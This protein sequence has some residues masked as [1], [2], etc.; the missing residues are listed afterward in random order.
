MNL[1]IFNNK[2]AKLITAAL[3]LIAG[4][5]AI[6]GCGGG[7]SSSSTA[8]PRLYKIGDID[9]ATIA[10]LNKAKIEVV[11]FDPSMTNSVPAGSS[12]VFDH[13]SIEL[14]EKQDAVAAKILQCFEAG[15]EV[16]LLSSDKSEREYLFKNI[17]DGYSA[18]TTDEGTI[19]VFGVTREKNGSAR[20]FLALGASQTSG[21][22]IS[23]DAPGLYAAESGDKVVVISGDE[24]LGTESVLDNNFQLIIT[25][26]AIVASG[27]SMIFNCDGA[28]KN[29][30]VYSLQDGTVTSEDLVTKPDTEP[31]AADQDEVWE[32]LCKWLLEDPDADSQAALTARAL[33]S[34][35]RR[36]SASP[37]Y[38]GNTDL[39]KVGQSFTKTVTQTIA[40]KFYAMNVF[41]VAVHDFDGDKDW[42]YVEQ[43]CSVN[44]ADGYTKFWKKGGERVENYM[45]C[46]AAKN[47]LLINNTA[48]GHDLSVTL[49]NA[50]PQAINKET[51]H[52]ETQSWSIGGK[53]GVAAKAAGPEAS[54]E[55]SFGIGA[56]SSKSWK[57]ADVDLSYNA[58][59]NEPTWTYNYNN[60]PADSKAI[61]QWNRMKEVPESDLSRSTF[62]FYNFWVWGID[63]EKRSG[64]PTLRVTPKVATGRTWT[65]GNGSLPCGRKEKWSLGTP[66]LIP[67]NAKAA[68]LIAL[69]SHNVDMD[70]SAEQKK[71]IKVASRGA[72][73]AATAAGGDWCT[74]L[75]TDDRLLIQVSENKTGK[76]RSAKIT[77][78]RTGTDD[79]QVVT[80]IQPSTAK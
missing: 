72:W 50:K 61:G 1:K 44:G 40:G 71:Y 42:Y 8:S 23:E 78:T 24:E 80:V 41:M 39:L 29:G 69:E 37:A 30:V 62:V 13:N 17:L 10:S 59:N 21:D 12:F 67:L 60:Y 18:D 38:A 4:V 73:N 20:S 77:V 6:G 74:L 58:G 34:V 2:S 47:E 15:G 57:V 26:G 19:S 49:T 63:S 43:E 28:V 7:S 14:V 25:S 51:T 16:V 76:A 64:N 45:R 70:S 11:Q 65:R 27:D 53:V 35:T 48:A 33:E 32:Y 46:A 79:K 52:N 55:L 36:L 22:V 3:L 56:S 5:I 9:A 31:E 54:G 75:A 68:P 66:A